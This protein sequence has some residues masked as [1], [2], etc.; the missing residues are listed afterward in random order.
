MSGALFSSALPAAPPPN[1]ESEGSF[2]GQ[3]ESVYDNDTKEAIEEYLD[4]GSQPDGSSMK[5]H[6]RSTIKVFKVWFLY[7]L[8]T[9]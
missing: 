5:I 8:W 4:S 6:R 9:K 7:G 2:S 1:M 3:N